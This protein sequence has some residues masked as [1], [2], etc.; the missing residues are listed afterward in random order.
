MVLERKIS[1]VTNLQLGQWHVGYASVIEIWE[2]TWMKISFQWS[3]QLVMKYL[4]KMPSWVKTHCVWW[5]KNVV[6]NTTF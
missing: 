6:T 1:W 4:K 2:F 3:G 5:T